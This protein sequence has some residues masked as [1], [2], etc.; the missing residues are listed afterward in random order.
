MFDRD[1]GKV[2]FKIFWIYKDVCFFMNFVDCDLGDIWFED[3]GIVNIVGEID[4]E[5]LLVRFL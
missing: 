3:Y 2:Y 1:F 5:M 4:E